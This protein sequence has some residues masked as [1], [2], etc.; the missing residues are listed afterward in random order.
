[1][2]STGADIESIGDIDA[3]AA[4]R[5]SERGKQV[6]GL[7]EELPCVTLCALNGFALGGGLELA[8]HC[9]LRVATASARLG[10]PEINLGIIP[11]WGGTQRLPQVVGRSRALR[12]ILSGEPVSGEAALAVGLVDEVVATYGELLPVAEKLA[13][14]FAD[15]ARGALGRA[16]RGVYGNTNDNDLESELFAEAWGSA[17]RRE[18]VAALIAKR[19]PVWPD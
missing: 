17:E 13:G 10:L 14:R 18:G 7:L 16:K 5:F 3:D 1:V 6:F 8:L 11:G 4:R 9:D 2:F 19:R 15:K 12:M